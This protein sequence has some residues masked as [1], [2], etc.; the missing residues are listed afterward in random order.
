MLDGNISYL[1]GTIT[2]RMIVYLIF[3]V[4]FLVKSCFVGLSPKRKKK[5][6]R[7]YKIKDGN[8]SIKSTRQMR[9]LIDTTQRKNENKHSIKNKEKKTYVTRT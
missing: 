5:K 2:T 4:F 3:N 8:P 1:F 7:I 9:T 6:N